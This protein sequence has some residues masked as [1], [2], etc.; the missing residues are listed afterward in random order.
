MVQIAERV[1]EANDKPRAEVMVDVQILE[2]SRERA[3]HYGLDLGSYSAALAFSPEAAPGATTASA[4]QPQHDFAGRQHRRLLPVGAVRG[5]AVPRKRFA[6]QGAGQA[7]PARRRRP[8]AVVEP[9]RRR[10]G[11]EHHLHAAGRPAAS[12]SNPLTSFGYRTIGIIVDMTPRVTYDG[13]IILDITIENSARGQDINIAGQNLPSFFSRKV[14][15]KLRLRDGESN[16]LAGL[17]REDERKIADGI[18]RASCGC[19]S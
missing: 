19:R 3:K 9:R 4:V 17:L 6:D 11:S 8:E 2:V 7:E 18:S 10:A 15:T 16:L 1:I 13:D 5:G 12:A 14:T